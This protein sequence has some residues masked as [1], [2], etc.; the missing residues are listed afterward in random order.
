MD[1]LKRSQKSVNIPKGYSAEVA[2]LQETLKLLNT[3]NS[4]T[5]KDLKIKE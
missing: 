2:E 5:D 1:K 4:Q 3:V